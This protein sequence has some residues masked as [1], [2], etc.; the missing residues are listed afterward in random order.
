MT[1]FTLLLNDLFKVNKNVWV[2]II[3]IKMTYSESESESDF[4]FAINSVS[5]FDSASESDSNSESESESDFSSVFMNL[6]I[7]VFFILYLH[8]SK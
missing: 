7:C 2:K 3:K 4:S 5:D 6:D 1:S 8:S